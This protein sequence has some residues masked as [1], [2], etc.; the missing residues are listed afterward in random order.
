MREDISN[1]YFEWIFGLVCNR[2]FGKGVSYRKLLARLHCTEFVYS[3]PRDRNR[4]QDGIDL[5]HRFVVCN[6]YEDWYDTIMEALDGKCSVLE[7]MIALAIRCE[8]NIMDDPHMG[9]RTGQWFWGMISNLGLGGMS[10]DAFNV[11]AVDYII[12]RFLDRKYEPDGE[13]GLF[14][15]K[16]CDVDLRTVEIWYQICRYLDTIT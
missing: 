5:R 8:E 15:I 2:R 4:A 10:D 9:D 6:G 13:G 12:K 1:E 14:T 7:M 16:R 3:I 11:D